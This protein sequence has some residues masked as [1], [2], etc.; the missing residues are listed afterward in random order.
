M[1]AV[2]ERLSRKVRAPPGRL[3]GNAWAPRGDGKGHRKQTALSKRKQTKG[4]GEKV[5]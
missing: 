5:G 2:A 4:K 1:V 3:P